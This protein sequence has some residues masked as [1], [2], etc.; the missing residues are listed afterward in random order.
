MPKN[1]LFCKQIIVKTACGSDLKFREKTKSSRKRFVGTDTIAYKYSYIANGF[2]I[3]TY[4]TLA[5][6]ACLLAQKDLLL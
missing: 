1:S 6:T 4:D 2:Y 5:H 3:I